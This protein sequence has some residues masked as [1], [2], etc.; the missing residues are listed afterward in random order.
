MYQKKYLKYKSRYLN[1]TKL[2]M[3]GALDVN[4]LLQQ[5]LDFYNVLYDIKKSMELPIFINGTKMT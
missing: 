1:L 5:K 4:D 3:G 2:M